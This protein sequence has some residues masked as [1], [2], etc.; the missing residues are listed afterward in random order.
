M[1]N[2]PMNDT[3]TVT[4]P[5]PDAAARRRAFERENIRA[6]CDIYPEAYRALLEVEREE[7][8][9]AALAAVP[10]RIYEITRTTLVRETVQVRART[11][12]HALDQHGDF[13]LPDL[14]YSFISSTGQRV[15]AY[16][17]LW[18]ESQCLPVTDEGEEPNV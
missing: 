10:T 1:E 2:R 16:Q 8:E 14:N 17:V 11:E 4:D 12:D 7:R 15:P 3:F 9:A 13:D 5:L 6:N 18:S